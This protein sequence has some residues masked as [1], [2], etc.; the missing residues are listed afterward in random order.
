MTWWRDARDSRLWQGDIIAEVPVAVALYPLTQLTRNK[1]QKDWGESLSWT[2]NREGVAN[3]IARGR[4]ANVIVLSHEC[5]IDKNESKGRVTVA[6]VI[7]IDRLSDEERDRVWSQRR[8]CKMPLPEI[9]NLGSC[10]GDLRQ[11]SA[12]DR[13]YVQTKNRLAS[14]SDEGLGRLRLQLIAFFTRLDA[15]SSLETL[16]KPVL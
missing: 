16:S 5:E 6:P 8:L 7:P 9:P 3:L 12:V 11:I 14:I 2:P 15:T 10:Y 13:Q 4:R 1:D